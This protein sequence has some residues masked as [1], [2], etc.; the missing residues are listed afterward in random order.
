LEPFWRPTHFPDFK[1]MADPYRAR[2]GIL[3]PSVKD[4][5]IKGPYHDQIDYKNPDKAFFVV[6]N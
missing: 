6:D 1:V 5:G 2:G 3:H 4:L